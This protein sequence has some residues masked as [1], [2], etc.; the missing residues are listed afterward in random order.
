MLRFSFLSQKHL[1]LA[2]I[3]DGF[4]VVGDQVSL[5]E[6]AVAHLNARALGF[7]A[8]EHVVVGERGVFFRALGTFV[9]VNERSC[10]N[11]F[12][13]LEGGGVDACAGE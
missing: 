10:S 8:G 11:L 13:V 5:D 1:P 9:F 12:P 6:G 4:V 7:G 2:H 3:V